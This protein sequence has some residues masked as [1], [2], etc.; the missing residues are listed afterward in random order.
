MIP[1]VKS[2]SL[3]GG[4]LEY[5]VLSALWELGPASARAVHEQVGE[6]R[7]LVYTTTAKVL[8]R[9]HHKGLVSRRKVGKAFVYLA[10]A[11]RE[12]IERARATD[13][14]TK[15][16]GNRPRPAMAALVDAVEA[17]D[18]AL[19]GELQR[20]VQARRRGSRGS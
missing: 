3:P 15:M 13:A 11:N 5:A 19:L 20:L 1:A 14:V 16:L 6:P 4:D 9:L 8:E 12:T 2:P 17:V 7:A 18:P 10:K